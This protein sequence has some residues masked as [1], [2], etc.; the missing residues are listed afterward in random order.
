MHSVSFPFFHDRSDS[1]HADQNTTTQALAMPRLGTGH[2]VSLLGKTSLSQI[3]SPECPKPLPHSSVSANNQ[4]S[5]SI[6]ILPVHSNAAIT[7][8]FS[9]PMTV[10]EE[11]R[12]VSVAPYAGSRT[13]GDNSQRDLHP[14][15]MAE[16]QLSTLSN[17]GP[18]RNC[19]RSPRLLGAKE[20]TLSSPRD[21]GS[22]HHHCV[23]SPYDRHP[24]PFPS[25]PEERAKPVLVRGSFTRGTPTFQEEQ[26]NVNSPV[27]SAQGQGGQFL[28]VL[29][30]KHGKNEKGAGVR[31]EQNTNSVMVQGGLSDRYLELLLMKAFMRCQFDSLEYFLDHHVDSAC[32]F[33]HRDPD[34][35]KSRKIYVKVGAYDKGDFSE[36]GPHLYNV[37]VAAANDSS[38]P[39]VQW[40]DSS[41]C[42]VAVVQLVG[43]KLKMYPPC[44]L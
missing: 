26:K 7:H 36:L 28:P 30:A 41:N 17:V 18:V 4:T 33:V 31:S 43:M 27:F 29:Q 24:G 2:S 14:M 44:F 40:Q 11:V 3:P 35:E 21:H 23:S 12:Y 32:L 15:Q 10:S 1:L 19:Y 20:T 8:C 9:P 37:L 25:M 42:E 38:Y 22:A 6:N 16:S 13:E 5:T 34:P 39:F